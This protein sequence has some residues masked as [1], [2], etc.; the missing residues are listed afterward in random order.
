L[1]SKSAEGKGKKNPPNQRARAGRLRVV[2]LDLKIFGGGGAEKE[3]CGR[4]N[5][6]RTNV[7]KS[8]EERVRSRFLRKVRGVMVKG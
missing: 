3:L 4:K 7:S 6:G 1:K 2:G 5:M 8:K